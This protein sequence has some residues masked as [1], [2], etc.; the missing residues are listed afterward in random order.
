MRRTGLMVTV[1]A[2][3]LGFAASALAQTAAPSQVQEVIVTAQ[4]RAQNINDVSTAI[5]AAS[6]ATLKAVGV[7]QVSDLTRIEPSLQFAPSPNDTPVYTLRGIGYNEQ[8]LAA[9]PTVSVYQD[10]VPY[11]LGPMAGG[12]LLDPE[13]VEILKG[14]QG[15]LFGQNA[16]GG[17]INF[18]TAKPTS[19]FTAG[20]DASWARFNETQ[21]DGYLSGPLTSTL[22]A[23]LSGSI[24]EGGAWQQS[25]TRDDTLGAKDK[26]VGR[27]L[28][29]WR[30]NDRLKVSVNLNGWLDHSQT[31]A[32]QLEGIWFADPGNISPDALTPASANFKPNAAYLAT[33]PTSVQQ[34]VAQPTN[35]S[36]DRQAD[37]VA[38][39]HPHNDESFYQGSIRSEYRLTDAINLTSITSYEDYSENNLVDQG[40]IGVANADAHIRGEAS[41]VYQ[42]F[43]LNGDFGQK[44]GAW[45]LGVNYE[46]DQNREDD[47]YND[48]GFSPI[49]TTGGS[50]YSS[51]PIA[52]IDYFGARNN[53]NAGTTSIF[54][55]IEYPIISA[56]T[57]NA[58]VRYTQS[59]QTMAGCSYGGAPLTIFTNA[60]AAQLA[61]AFGGPAPTPISPG[62]CGTFGPAPDFQ[63]GLQHN[64]LDQSNVPWRVG[65][66]WRPA[67]NELLYFSISQG[68]KAGTSPSITASSYTELKPVTQ[69]ALLSYEVGAKLALLDNQL[70]VNGAVFHYDYTNKQELGR[71]IEPVFN[72]LETLVNIPKSTEDGAELSAVWR[73]I[74]GLTLNGSVTY[75]DSQVT[76]NFI[77]YSPYILNIADT[78]NYKGDSFPDTPRWS[79]HY[80]ARY[81][82][83]ATDKLMAY[84]AADAS[85]QSSS[86]GAFGATHAEAIGAPS[87]F[88]KGYGLLNL[89]AGVQSVDKKWLVEA[90]GRNVTNTYYWQT[91]FWNGDTTLRYAGMPTTYGVRLSYKY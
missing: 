88:I 55:H 58:G 1:C 14:P 37:W 64:K 49:Y 39:T 25:R 33:Y 54:S 8:S 51:A 21:L 86:Y 56:V 68:Y 46:Y 89:A 52:P 75:L 59:D 24:D 11:P 69:E 60:S 20:V 36:N 44:R 70:Q 79:V 7:T 57:L 62:Q 71:V 9:T 43:R 22:E 16:T 28:L 87:L 4:K 23:R 91:A 74:D 81:D 40:G 2:A 82:W 63:P 17:A 50:P 45:I 19:Y 77:N 73:P 29:D 84:V 61:A 34:E 15:T 31:Q 78:V 27:L 48:L 30:P 26:Q 41:S 80:G 6:G 32:A 42:E 18:V 83:R 5:T 35:P 67:K 10:E 72:S 85:Y 3:G 90:F 13:R 38:G 12:V 66:D 76:S 65:L 47:L 53:V